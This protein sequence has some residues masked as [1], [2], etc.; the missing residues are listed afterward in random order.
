[1]PSPCLN[2]VAAEEEDQNHFN[3]MLFSMLINSS[4]HVTLYLGVPC[5]VATGSCSVSQMCGL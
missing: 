3:S 2:F 5:A 1:M 4:Y